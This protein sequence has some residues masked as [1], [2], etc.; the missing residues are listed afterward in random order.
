MGR[1][2][3]ALV[4]DGTQ[5]A[6][7]TATLLQLV[8]GPVIEVGPGFTSL[9]RTS[10]H[11]PG[12]GPL[13]ATAA[14][15]A[16]LA[17]RDHAGSA[18][19]VATDLPRLTPA[20]LTILADHPVP[21]PDHSVVPRDAGGRP[22]PLCARYSATALAM[23]Q[24]LVAEGQ[25]SMKA[26]LA[27]V[28]VTWLDPGPPDPG[29]PDPGTLDPSMPVPITWLDHGPLDP[30]PLDDIDTPEDLAA[31]LHPRQ[32]TP[33]PAPDPAPDPTRDPAPDPKP[34]P[35]PDAT[36]DPTLRR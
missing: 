20:Y 14:G 2:K 26:L 33:D 3:A 5:L 36:P 23:A 22:Q 27:A 25:H 35:A 11:P 24:S 8:A 19:V 32:P 1:D 16:E 30:S 9:P 28:P 34:D 21:T 13:A 29:T 17:R 10:E 18:L 7:R 31:V 12:S 15:A 6:E 4:I